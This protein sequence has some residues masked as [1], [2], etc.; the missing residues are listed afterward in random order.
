MGR[1]NPDDPLSP[2]SRLNRI[3]PIFPTQVTV[4][5]M[6]SI[7]HEMKGQDLNGIVRVFL[8]VNNRKIHHQRCDGPSLPPSPRHQVVL[9][10]FRVVK[11][12]PHYENFTVKPTIE[13]RGCK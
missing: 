9:D 3:S 12:P 2:P 5:M 13:P 7:V 10:V 6:T 4:N 8:L 11:L 1:R